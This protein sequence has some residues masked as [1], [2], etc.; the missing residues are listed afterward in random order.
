MEVKTVVEF[1]TK[2]LGAAQNLPEIRTQS[3]VNVTEVIQGIG[4]VVIGA[5]VLFEGLSAID[6]ACPGVCIPSRRRGEYE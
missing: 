6:G 5:A 2:A 3:G 1:A 4:K